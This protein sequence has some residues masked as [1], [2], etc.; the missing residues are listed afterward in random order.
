MSIIHTPL[1]IEMVLEGIEK[2]GP[3]YQELEIGGTK[4]LVEPQGM[5]KC[6]VVRLLSTNPR[7]YLRKEFQP[8]AEISFVP[9]MSSGMDYKN[10]Q[11]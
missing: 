5:D 11:I 3:Q 6:R 4:L 10:P 2:E 9:Q 7:D 8:G 1:P